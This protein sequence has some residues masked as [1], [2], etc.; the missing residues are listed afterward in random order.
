MTSWKS[1]LTYQ[2][3]S[4]TTQHSRPSKAV[5]SKVCNGSWA[6][7]S[8]SKTLVQFSLVLILES[9]I[10]LFDPNCPALSN[11]MLPKHQ[12]LFWFYLFYF[13]FPLLSVLFWAGSVFTSEFVAFFFSQRTCQTRLMPDFNNCWVKQGDY[14]PLKHKGERYAVSIVAL[15][16][17]IKEHRIHLCFFM[18]ITPDISR[19]L[20]NIIHCIIF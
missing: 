16:L 8:G 14:T 13:L 4:T 7:L 2:Q 11:Y 18:W 5:Q 1:G 9:A 20:N 6:H 12:Q 19:A 10:G 15:C 3:H 17:V